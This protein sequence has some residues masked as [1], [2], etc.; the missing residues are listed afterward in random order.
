MSIIFSRVNLLRSTKENTYYSCTVHDVVTVPYAMRFHGLDAIL[1]LGLAWH[2][3]PRCHVISFSRP[4][5]GIYFLT[6]VRRWNVG[7]FLFTTVLFIVSQFSIKFFFIKEN[8]H[9]KII[10]CV[11]VM[12]TMCPAHCICFYEFK[13]D[14][15]RSTRFNSIKNLFDFKSYLQRCICFCLS[16]F[17]KNIQEVEQWNVDLFISL[18]P[19]A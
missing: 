6:L 14:Q 8:F 10:G 3:L 16:P 15:L 13:Q 11:D 2:I 18:I 5:E 9:S 1:D 7:D 19:G 17:L 12:L 4:G